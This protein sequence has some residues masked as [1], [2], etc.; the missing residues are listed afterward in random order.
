[1]K[2][3]RV[4]LGELAEIKEINKKNKELEN[5]LI[6]DTKTILDEQGISKVN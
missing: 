4:L 1:M 3:L 6:K 2:E 5:N